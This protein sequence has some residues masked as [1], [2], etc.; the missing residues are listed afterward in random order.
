MIFGCCLNMNAK[1]PYGVGMDDINVISRAGFDYVELPLAEVKAMPREVFFE[2][3]NRLR[4]YGIPCYSFNNFFPKTIRLTGEERNL[5]AIIEYAKRALICASEL[6]AS[7]IV[8]GS[9][10][11]KNIPDGFSMHEGYKQITEMLSAIALEAADHRLT[12]V[13][14]PLRKAECNIINRFEEGVQL[15]RDVHEENVRVLV[16]FYHLSVEKEPINNIRKFGEEYLG[17]VHF[18][19]PE[20][21]R[22]P[23]HR[24]EDPHYLDFFRVLRDVGYCGGVSLEAYSSDVAEE[25][26]ISLSVMRSLYEQVKSEVC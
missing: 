2:L 19:F 9:G 3:K 16:D 24:D 21:R 25:A 22:Y 5:S 12:V 15:A 17:H 10:S 14:E 8:F 4:E 26:K 11:A 1:D 13:I 7:R 20:G 18:A 6:G 23:L